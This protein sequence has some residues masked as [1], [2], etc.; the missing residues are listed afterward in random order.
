MRCYFYINV[1]SAVILAKSIFFQADFYNSYLNLV[2]HVSTFTG[3]NENIYH[4][5]LY[6]FFLTKNITASYL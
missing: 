6:N 1:F 5:I 2:V 3:K 4:C